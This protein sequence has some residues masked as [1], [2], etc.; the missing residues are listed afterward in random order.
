MFASSVSPSS[1]PAAVSANRSSGW[2]LLV[3]ILLCIA[4]LAVPA[5]AQAQDEVDEF[6]YDPTDASFMELL[7]NEI[8]YEAQVAEVLFELANGQPVTNTCVGARVGEKV[9]ALCTSDPAPRCPSK[10]EC[11]TR[12]GLS[13]KKCSCVTAQTTPTPT[14]TPKPGTPTPTPKPGTPPAPSQG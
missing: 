8:L 7:E 3:V 14:P 10:Q 2:L 4:P 5:A 11:R 13:G 1:R 6:L 9:G 12:A